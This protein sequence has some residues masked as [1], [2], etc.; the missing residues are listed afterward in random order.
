MIV[1]VEDERGILSRHR[2]RYVVG[3]D[4]GHLVGSKIGVSMTGLTGITE[5]VVVHF[6]AD[7]SKYWDDR[8]F[9][10]YFINGNGGT[11]FESGAIVPHGP[12][13]GKHCREWVFHFGFDLNDEARNQE[14]KLLPRI[15]ETLKIPN[16]EIKVKRISHWIIE[17][18]V[19][20]L[21]DNA[22]AYTP[23][24]GEIEIA[25]EVQSSVALLTVANSDTSLTPDDLRKVFDRFWRK[26]PARRNGEHSG[27][28]LSVSLALMH[29]IGGDLTAERPRPGV[30]RLTV[31]VP[32][33]NID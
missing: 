26:D 4:G 6:E 21:V 16:L 31:S 7:L 18:V 11:V 2:A 1:S 25:S 3:A 10:C 15:R 22:V 9:L 32:R 30:V 29:A 17:S 8:V 20:S 24:G 5:M 33:L 23:P 19:A 14:A 28:G 12:V 13:W 27:L